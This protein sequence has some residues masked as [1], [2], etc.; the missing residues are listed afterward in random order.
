LSEIRVTTI[1]DAAG[2][3]PVTLTKQYAAKAWCVW[4]AAVAPASIRKSENISSL[5]DNGQG[6]FSFAYTNNF[7]DSN[8][9]ISGCMAHSSTVTNF[10]YNVQPQQNSDVVAGS[11]R[12]LT[13]Y[14]GSSSGNSD[15]VYSNFTAHGDLA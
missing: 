11:V 10:V 4:N 6:D 2:T 14:S 5:T 8:Y 12:L 1:S 7:A 9:T 15:Y 3:G 13:V